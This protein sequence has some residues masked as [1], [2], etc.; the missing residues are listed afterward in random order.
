MT[1]GDYRAKREQFD[2]AV[3]DAAGRV[4]D[5]PF[6]EHTMGVAA[7]FAEGQHMFDGPFQ[8]LTGKLRAR[9]CHQLLQIGHKTLLRDDHVYFVWPREAMQE[10][11]AAA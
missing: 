8:I 4:A 5:V 10:A 11:G 9:G 2:F 3:Q 1:W 6:S 7:V